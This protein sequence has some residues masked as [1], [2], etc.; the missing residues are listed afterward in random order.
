M[1]NNYNIAVDMTATNA[2]ITTVDT[3]VDEI[4]D[5]DVPSLGA[6]IGTVDTVVDAV[7]VITD[8]IDL[9]LPSQGMIY[10]MEA[11]NDQA[12]VESND[13]LHSN[14]AEVTTIL[15]VY[16]KKK[17]I[18]VPFTG[19]YRVKFDLKDGFSGDVV[20][21]KIYL[22]G[23]AHGIEQTNNTDTYVTKSEDLAFT[24]GDL[25][26]LY[27]ADAVAARGCFARNLRLYGIRVFGFIDNM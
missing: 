8:K 27:I 10:T 21:G 15:N 2:L 20:M 11:V 18:V 22:G 14:D 6:M 23:V 13:L 4:R 24:A 9:C 19:T 3:V 12:V 7:K 26:Q 25:L 5:V 1:S 17:E 16:T